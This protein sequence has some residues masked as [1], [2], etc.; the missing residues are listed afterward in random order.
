MQQCLHLLQKP[1]CHHRIHPPVDALLHI[2]P[3]P[4]GQAD[5]RRVVP[6]RYLPAFSVVRPD[7]LPRLVIDLQRPDDPLLI[8]QVQPRRALRVHGPQRLQQRLRAILRQ[9]F[10]QFPAYLPALAAGGKVLPPHQRVQIQP[11]AP[12]QHRP[13]SPPQDVLHTRVRLPDVPGHGPAL[14]RVRHGHHVVGHALHLLRRGGGGADGHAPVEL[15]GVHGHH[16]AV[17]ALCQRHAHL[18]LAAG[19]GPHH[20][21]DLVVHVLTSI[22]FGKRRSAVM[23]CKVVDF[24]FCR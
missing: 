16:L 11:R 10:L 12:H 1:L 19:R 9:L 17:K 6:G 2:L 22:R 20:A 4:E 18:R 8:P 5:V 15:H 24:S 3:V 13:I 7:G 23:A 14:R 21:D